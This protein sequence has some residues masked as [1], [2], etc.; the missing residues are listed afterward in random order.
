MNN[1]KVKIIVYENSN[2]FLNYLVYHS[3]YYEDL[4]LNDNYILTIDYEDYKKISRRY[5]TKIIKYYGKRFIVNYLDTNKY[6]LISL[7]ISFLVLYLLTNTIFKININTNDEKLYN[8]INNSLKENNIS[9]YKRKKSFK[10]LKKIKLKLVLDRI[11][12]KY[13]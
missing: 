8:L 9:I 13:Y 10:E 12:K 5:K 4:T 1:N 11:L 7:F 6:M 3:I 2:K